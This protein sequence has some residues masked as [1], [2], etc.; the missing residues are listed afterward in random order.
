MKWYKINC[1]DFASSDHTTIYD[2][3]YIKTE[4]TTHNGQELKMSVRTK[5]ACK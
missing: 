3:E 4:P 2:S 5:Q 1:S